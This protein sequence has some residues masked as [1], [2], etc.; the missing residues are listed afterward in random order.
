MSTERDFYAW[1]SVSGSRRRS[2]QT[3][4]DVVPRPTADAGAPLAGTS[5]A[6]SPTPVSW[7]QGPIEWVEFA[8]GA[9]FLGILGATLWMEWCVIAS[10][11]RWIARWL[12]E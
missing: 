5:P 7:R 11:A 9:A 3:I 6:A 2:L 1:M 10:L 4:A 12:A 8:R